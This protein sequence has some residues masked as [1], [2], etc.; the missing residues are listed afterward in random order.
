MKAKVYRGTQEI[1]GTCIE[2]T[3][4]NGKILWIDLGAPLDTKNPNVEYAQNKVDALLISHPHQDHFGLMENV[5]SQVPVYI[6]QLSLDLIN[7]TKIFLDKAPSTGN[8][9]II[10]PWV[11][12]TIADTFKVKPFLTD[13]SSPEAFAFLIEADGKRVFY[14]GDFRATGRKGVVFENLIKRPPPNIDLLLVEGTMVERSNHLYPTE[15]SVEKAIV[16]VIKYQRNISFVISSAQNI[17]RF[18]SVFRAC[19]KTR[20]FMVID[21]YT[22]WI[23]EMVRKKAK[24]VPA[25]EWEEIKVYE[26][27]GQ[28]KKITGI[29][30]DNFRNRV[31]QQII[32]NSVFQRPSDFVYFL[33][34][35]NNKL[36]DKMRGKGSINVIYSQWD[37]YLREEHKTYCT[38]YINSLKADSEISFHNIHTSGHATVADLMLFAKAINPKTVVP[39][40]TAYPQ[41]FK[42]EFEKEGFTNIVLWEDGQEYQL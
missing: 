7:A 11:S 14:S 4:D 42:A 19:M 15:D 5:G 31:H 25:I 10:E 22:A 34:C 18:V 41:T 38:D 29:E 9:K 16:D 13:H 30:F 39:I 33:R 8:F 37:G 35:P 1:G 21:I 23:I 27:P 3:A 6:G 36:V 26:H 12:N 24:G 17:D 40:H 28:L 32:G 20:K 2:L